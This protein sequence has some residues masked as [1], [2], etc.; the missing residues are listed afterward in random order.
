MA[1][2]STTHLG[3]SVQLT[4]HTLKPFSGTTVRDLVP[5][6]IMCFLI[7]TVK[8]FLKTDLIGWYAGASLLFKSWLT[9]P[10]LGG[11]RGETVECVHSFWGL[12][13]YVWLSQGVILWLGW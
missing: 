12:L 8:E 1:V 2:G 9:N 10:L 7:N 6:T 3:G 4:A 5:K 11:I 13:Q